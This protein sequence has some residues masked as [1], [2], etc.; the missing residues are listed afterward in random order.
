[1]CYDA[2]MKSLKLCIALYCALPLCVQG[3]GFL[4]A[5]VDPGRAGVFLDGKYL[6]PAAN[7]KFARKYAV[8]PGDHEVKLIDPRYE[9]ITRKVT[10]TAGKTTTLTE[11]MHAVPLAKPPFGKIRTVGFQKYDAVYVNGKYYGHAD[12]FSNGSQYLCL[13]PGT[14]TVK[15]VPL[16]GGSDHEEKVTLEAEKMTIVK[17]K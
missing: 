2:G 7:F 16:A 8:A 10:I 5:K 1:M 15:V 17:A 13:N 3:Q 6:G 11:T 4:K 12:E 9:E 14:Y